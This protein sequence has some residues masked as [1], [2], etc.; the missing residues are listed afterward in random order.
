MII[1]IDIAVLLAELAA[2]DKIGTGVTLGKALEA[3]ALATKHAQ[4][5]LDE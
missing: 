1:N 4:D 3:I 5:A 2:I